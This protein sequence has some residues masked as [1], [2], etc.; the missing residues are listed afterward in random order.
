[1]IFV[2]QVG[3][4]D[5]FAD[6]YLYAFTGDKYADASVGSRGNLFINRV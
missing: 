2:S 5:R 1:M 6:Y 4:H 3:Q